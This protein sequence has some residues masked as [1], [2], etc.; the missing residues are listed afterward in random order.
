V[1]NQQKVD[2]SLDSYVNKLI[3]RPEEWEAIVIACVDVSLEA[4]ERASGHLC[5]HSLTKRRTL[6]FDN[7]PL[8][9]LYLALELYYTSVAATGGEYKQAPLPVVGSFLTFLCSQPEPC[10]LNTSGIPQALETLK[11]IRDTT[12][13]HSC[14]PIFNL[15]FRKW[16]HKIRIIDVVSDT[17]QVTDWTSDE[18]VAALSSVSDSLPGSSSEQRDFTLRE[19]YIKPDNR[20]ERLR[21][22]IVDVDDVLG[23]GFVKGSAAGVLAPS[24]GGKTVAA[25]QLASGLLYHNGPDT[26]GAIVSTEQK[27]YELLP[28]LA[29]CNLK[30][31]FEG[32][33]TGIVYEDLDPESAKKV[34]T[35]MNDFGERLRIHEWEKK[36]GATTF[37][38]DMEALIKRYIRE[39]GRLDFIVFDWLGASL[40]GKISDR[41]ELL[42]IIYKMAA[43]ALCDLAKDYNL[44]IIFFGQAATKE[45]VGKKH[46]GPGDARECKDLHFNTT[47][48]WGISGLKTTDK[49]RGSQAQDDNPGNETFQ[50]EQYWTFD[51]VRMG[52]PKILKV[53]RDFGFQRF[54][55]ESDNKARLR[56]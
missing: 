29:S 38:A 21:T 44:V 40:N 25:C 49:V 13:G 3:N 48:F 4:M 47:V 56:I 37:F 30:I 20:V 51:K 43:E 22:G 52:K 17:G 15:G 9:A 41:P 6:E 45:A 32:M 53:H 18:M 50:R 16:L 31:P 42:R 19:L 10:G 2:K 28:R 39:M 5:V 54:A 27:A 55:F 33:E 23:G 14:V 26:R 24:G 11:N 1:S 35:M 36:S 34:D 12:D 7:R 46:I 8:N